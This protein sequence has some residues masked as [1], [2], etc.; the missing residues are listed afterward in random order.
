MRVSTARL[1]VPLSAA[2]TASSQSLAASDRARAQSSAQV[3]P[4][5][6]AAR[7][8]SDTHSQYFQVCHIATPAAR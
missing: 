5:Q 1:A 2:K 3:R 7:P 4:D 8:R 6:Q